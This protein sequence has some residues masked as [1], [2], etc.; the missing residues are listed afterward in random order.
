MTCRARAGVAILTLVGLGTVARVQQAQTARPNILF[1]LA[2]DL[3]AAELAYLPQ[4]KA[5]L[6]DQGAS[7]ANYFVSVSLCCPSRSTML[8]GQYSHNT[9]VMTNGGS[10]GGFETAFAQGI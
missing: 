2:D 8:R 4:V 9:G 1:V 7:F 3:D 10:N 5:L 6:S